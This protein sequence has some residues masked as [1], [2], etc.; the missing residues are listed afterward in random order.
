MDT[1]TI[2]DLEV[3]YCVGVPD[4]ERAEPQRLLLT[5]ELRHDFAAAATHD[6]VQE[7][8]DYA[9]VCERLL[10]FGAGR[11]W[12]LIETLAEDVA[13]MLLTEF[14]PAS[15]RVKVKKFVIPQAAHVSVTVERS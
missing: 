14:G 15:V 12:R 13:R 10:G 3:R 6:D 8:I 5:I 7:T 2:K 9:R 11:H 4:A 1:I